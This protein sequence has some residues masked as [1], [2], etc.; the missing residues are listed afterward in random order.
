VTVRPAVGARYRQ[1]LVFESEEWSAAYRPAR[2]QNEGVNGFMK[3]GAFEALKDPQRRRVRGMAAQT[4]LAAFGLLAA[5]LRMVWGFLGQRV[6][7]QVR[8]RRSRRTSPKITDYSPRPSKIRVGTK[9]EPT[10]RT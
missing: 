7:A 9:P 6:Q 2:S 10:P 4:V 3:D 1:P 5:N 8:K